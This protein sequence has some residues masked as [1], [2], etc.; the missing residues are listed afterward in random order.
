MVNILINNW[1][2]I[3]G[4]K[5]K[6]ILF[7]N[8]QKHFSGKFIQCLACFIGNYKVFFLNSFLHF[9]H[10]FFRMFFEHS[11][12]NMPHFFA[13]KTKRKY[14]YSFS[15]FFILKA[16]SLVNDGNFAAS[17]HLDRKNSRSNRKDH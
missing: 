9:E 3:F 5:F 10:S 11:K 8:I 1:I 2:E 17:K 14:F 16:K 12:Q 6:M 4:K 13:I 15:I 7:S